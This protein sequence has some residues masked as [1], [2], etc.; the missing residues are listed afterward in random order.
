M[1]KRRN[2]L[3]KREDHKQETW[4]LFPGDDCQAKENNSRE[5]TFTS[6]IEDPLF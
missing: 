2:H 3:I 4:M 1:R 6:P 5:L